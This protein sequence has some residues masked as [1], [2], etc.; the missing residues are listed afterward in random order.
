MSDFAS[1]ENAAALDALKAQDRA[2]ATKCEGTSAAVGGSVLPHGHY[3][4]IVIK[5]E[6]PLKN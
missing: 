2:F 3:S 5:M 1:P 6:I 4:E